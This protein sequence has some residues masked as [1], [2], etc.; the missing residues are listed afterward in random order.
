MIARGQIDLWWAD[1]DAPRDAGEHPDDRRD[2]ARLVDRRAR[3][4]LFARRSTLRE[5]LGHYLD[6]RSDQVVLSRTPSGRPELD[7]PR[8]DLH[9]NASSSAGT[10]LYAITRGEPIGVDLEH[11]TRGPGL[12]SADHLFLTEAERRMVSEVEPRLRPITLLRLWTLKEALAK[13]MGTGLSSDPKELEF[14][15]IQGQ[16]SPVV[17]SPGGSRWRGDLIP[18]PEGVVAALAVRGDWDSCQQHRFAERLLE[19]ARGSA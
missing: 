5:L 16:P 8:S 18:T 15:F 1:L 17:V 7:W 6:C 9:F 14:R 12:T 3:R 10:A 13:A 19:K 4:R 2:A 11:S